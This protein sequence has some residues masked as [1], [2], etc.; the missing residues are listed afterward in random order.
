MEQSGA[1]TLSSVQARSTIGSDRE[2]LVQGS[3]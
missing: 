1:E 2:G 3:K